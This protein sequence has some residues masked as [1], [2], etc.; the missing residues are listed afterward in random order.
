MF[1]KHTILTT[2][3]HTHT[4]PHKQL[5]M[6]ACLTADI[7]QCSTVINLIHANN[8]LCTNSINNHGMDLCQPR[9]LTDRTHPKHN[10]PKG[11]GIT[12]D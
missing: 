8:C 4:I 5:H 6:Q 11:M 1:L 12:S 2:A 10:T 7:A 9:N 3:S